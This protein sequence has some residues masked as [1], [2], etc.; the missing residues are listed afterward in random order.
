MLALGLGLAGTAPLELARMVSALYGLWGVQFLA[1]A[2]GPVLGASATTTALAASNDVDLASRQQAAATIRQDRLAQVRDLEERFLLVL[3]GVADGSVDPADQVVRRQC[4][5]Q[6]GVLR[7]LLASASSSGGTASGLAELER[8]VEAAEARG[9]TVDVRLHGDL[10]ALPTPVRE[11]MA[12]T[13]AE[14]LASVATGTVTL[15]VLCSAGEGTVYV[16]FPLPFGATAWGDG[17]WGQALLDVVAV[18]VVAS[19]LA[20]PRPRRTATAGRHDRCVHVTTD[21]EDGIA[22]VELHWGSTAA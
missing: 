9:V 19:P 4:A 18:A 1:A 14:A 15:T 10:W 13:V 16:T 17:R 11:R 8:P 5:N 12:A 20:S 6:A 7:R 3:R 21:V 22:C 2:F